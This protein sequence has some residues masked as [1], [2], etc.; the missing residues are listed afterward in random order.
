MAG[1]TILVGVGS[2]HGDDQVGLRVAERLARCS[3]PTVEVRLAASPSELLDWLEGADQLVVCDACRIPAP[4]GSVFRWTW[5]AAE[6]ENT[7]FSG[8][9]DLSLPAVLTLAEQLGRLPPRVSVWGIS[10]SAAQ[11]TGPVSAEAAAAVPSVVEQILQAI[12]HA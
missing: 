5:P 2:Q 11:P 7:R 12:D 1:R 9:H 3:G 6:I 10:I 8:S 4:V